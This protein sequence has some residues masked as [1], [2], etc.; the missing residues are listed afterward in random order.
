LL[1]LGFGVK[2]KSKLMFPIQFLAVKLDMGIE[3]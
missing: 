1:N 3:A 2:L